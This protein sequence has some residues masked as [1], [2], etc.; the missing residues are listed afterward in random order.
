MQTEDCCICFE[1]IGNINNCTTPCGHKFCF[2]CLIKSF[3]K[4]TACPLCRAELENQEPEPQDNNDDIWSDTVS[5]TN[6]END[7]FY[8]TEDDTDDDP[9]ENQ[10]NAS[11]EEL[12]QILTNKGFTMTDM[13]AMFLGRSIDKQLP[14]YRNGK[15]TKMYDEFESILQIADQNARNQNARNQNARKEY[16]ERHQMMEEDKRRHHRRPITFFENDEDLFT[17]F[18]ER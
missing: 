9:I 7:Y 3:Q 10:I 1:T 12:T 16:T 2:K 4:N 5:E 6:T 15:L 17:F 18:T 14:R 8:E 11:A 13:I